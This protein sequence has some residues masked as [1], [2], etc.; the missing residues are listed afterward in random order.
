MFYF[1]MFFCF[2]LF[3]SRRASL[4]GFIPVN[5]QSRL[6]LYHCG[7]KPVI[8]H[9]ITSHLCAHLAR[10]ATAP[11][12]FHFHFQSQI[13]SPFSRSVSSSTRV[14]MNPLTFSINLFSFSSFSFQFIWDGSTKRVPYLQISLFTLYI[15]GVFLVLY[16]FGSLI[17]L[18]FPYNYFRV[19]CF[20]ACL[21]ASATTLSCTS[22]YELVNKNLRMPTSSCLSS[23]LVGRFQH[24]GSYS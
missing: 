8:T 22:V 13:G 19:L 5:H 11:S 18:L 6:L 3:R 16:V 14:L 15:R 12:L 1:E 24:T 20:T 17:S 4:F 9:C 21:F 7:P 23:G 2:S 10:Q